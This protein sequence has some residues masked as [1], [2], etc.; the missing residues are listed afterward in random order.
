[1]LTI[2][3]KCTI[4]DNENDVYP[5]QGYCEPTGS[6]YVASRN[7]TKSLSRRRLEIYEMLIRTF[8]AKFATFSVRLV[9]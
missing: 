1:M 5:L 8:G 3:L 9:G 2:R 4:T 7:L 6:L